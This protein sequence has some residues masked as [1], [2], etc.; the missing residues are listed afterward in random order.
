MNSSSGTPSLRPHHHPAVAQQI[1]PR[2]VGRVRRG[3]PLPLLAAEDDARPRRLLHRPHE[4]RPTLR[5]VDG[6][7]VRGDHLL[8][9]MVHAGAVPDAIRLDPQE[10]ARAAAARPIALPEPEV[11]VR[12][13]RALVGREPRIAV[14][15]QDR[16]VDARIGVDARRQ[17][18]QSPAE[19]HDQLAGRPQ[20]QP[21]V[22]RAVRLE[23]GAVVVLAQVA[24]KAQ[25]GGI[26]T[27]E[28]CHGKTVGR[29]A[30]TCLCR[31]EATSS[32]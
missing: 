8:V 3:H 14:E 7:A 24:Q 30:V 26:E 6:R 31:P 25:G 22:V 12:L 27:G 18:R 20:H 23:P 13:V 28:G 32:Q 17:A 15:P 10:E 19:R 11:E 21:L 5:I 16:A 1:A 9:E 2:V 29:R 4:L